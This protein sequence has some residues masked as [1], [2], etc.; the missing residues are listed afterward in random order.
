MFLKA[1]T[2]ILS[3][4]LILS[5]L[6]V[7]TFGVMAISSANHTGGHLCP[8]SLGGNCSLNNNF[9]SSTLH[10]I[11]GIQHLTQAVTTINSDLLMIFTAFLFSLF[12]VCIK[13]FYK[14]LSCRIISWQKHRQSTNFLIS[15]K[16]KILRW[17]ILNN[18]LHPQT[19]R[20]VYSEI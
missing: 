20:W 7:G 13:P 1:R 11:S 16:K 18:T 14:F 5:A 19:Y 2:R 17:F 12:L 10:H 6:F 4:I 3:V 15:K 9:L 8:V